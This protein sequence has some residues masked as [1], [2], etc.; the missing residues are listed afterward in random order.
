MLSTSSSTLPICAGDSVL[1]EGNYYSTST[2]FPFTYT[3]A[4]GCDS[5]VTYNVVVSPTPNFNITGGAIINLGQSVNLAVLPGVAGTSYFWD[6]PVGLSCLFCQNPIATP[7]SSMWYYVTVT[8]AAGCSII[9]SVYIEVDP[10]SNIYVPNIFSPNEDGANDIYFIRGKGVKQFNLA[11]Y[12]RW[13]QLVFESD[14]IEKGWD[15]TKEGTMMNQG[16]FVYKLNVIMHDG[17]TIKQTGNIT[18]VR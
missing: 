6:P 10:S 7:P 11:I 2:S 16:V 12:N 15:G 9:D 17:S 3:N 1:I 4:L 5:V 13:G 8:N 14:D 18:L